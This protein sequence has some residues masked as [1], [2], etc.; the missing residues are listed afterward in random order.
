M[1][2][3]DEN[4]CVLGYIYLFVYLYVNELDEVV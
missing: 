2:I 3:I 4:R 1:I